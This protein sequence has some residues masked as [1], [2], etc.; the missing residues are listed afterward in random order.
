MKVMIIILLNK[1]YYKFIILG[2]KRFIKFKIKNNGH[3]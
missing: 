3:N 2:I 1:L